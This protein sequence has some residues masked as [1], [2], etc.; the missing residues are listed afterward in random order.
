MKKLRGALVDFPIS[1]RFKLAALWTSVMFC[2]VYGDIFSLFLPTRLQNL[3][4]GQSGV[5]AT[6]PTALLA[7]SMLMSLPAA[8]IAFSLVLKP[9]F[10][11]W[12]NVGVGI[13]FTGVMILIGVTTVSGWMMFYTYLAAVEV[14]LTSLIVVYAWRWER[15][16]VPQTKH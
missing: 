14:V 16:P 2:Y 8:M 6:T 13:F 10:A 5:G 1:V 3:M 15:E 7:F 9:A 12:I 11:R 4:N